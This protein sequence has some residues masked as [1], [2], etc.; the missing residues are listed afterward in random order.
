MI[1]TAMTKHAAKLAFA[2]HQGQTEDCGI[3]YISHPWHL[4]EQMDTEVETAVALLHDVVEDTDWTLEA[5]A[6]EGFPPQVLEP[7][8]LLT[9]DPAEPYLDYV[10]RIKGDPVARKVKLA[11]LRHNSDLT[12]LDQ[13]TEHDLE[14]Q[15]KYRQALAILT[16]DEDNQRLERQF[17]FILELDKEKF[18]Q[19]QT[20]LTDGRR[21]ENDAEHAWHMALMAILLQEYANEPVDVLKTV[22]MILLHDVVEIDAGDTYAYDEAGKATQAQREQAA[23]ERLFGL[24]PEEQGRAMKGLWEEFEARAT[25]EARFARVMDNLQP[26]MLNHATGGKSWAEHGV[27]L[28][29][30]LTRNEITPQGSETLWRYARERFIQPHV[31]KELAD[32]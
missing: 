10:R 4:A 23:A 28:H 12:R 7:L 26:L 1:Y 13:V 11:D 21:R 8:A 22:T 17:R 5:L 2:A 25:P 15:E 31:G 30:V 29:N 27:H 24:L 3:P 14:R 9:H 16:E 6:A 19:R 32:D 18:I 20:Y